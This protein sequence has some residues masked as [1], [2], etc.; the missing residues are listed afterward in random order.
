MS[1]PVSEPNTITDWIFL[2]GLSREKAHWGNFIA[3]CESELGW[4]CHAIDLPGF[5]SEH[6]RPSPLSIAEIRQDIQQRLPSAITEPFGIVALSLGGMVALDWLAN[7]NGD[8]AAAILIST[9]SADCGLLNRLKPSAVPSTLN[10]LLSTSIQSQERAILNMVS[11]N[12]A[13]HTELL[14]Q[15]CHIRERRPAT[16]T[17]VIR[18]LIAASRFKSPPTDKLNKVQGYFISSRADR[19]VSHQCSEYLATKYHYPLTLHNSAG[20]DLPIDDADWL[21]G[22]FR[23]LV[24]AT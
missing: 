16:K 10:A 3:R 13:Q 24:V 11:N 5:G 9:S 22:V 4:R 20:H 2:R 18:Q 7:S 19:M 6:H 17:N 23:Q 15:W 1:Q 8:I 12:K 14:Q 21:I